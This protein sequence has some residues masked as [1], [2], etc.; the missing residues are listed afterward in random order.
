MTEKE[1]ISKREWEK[2]GVR[3]TE[4]L[5]PQNG[6]DESIWNNNVGSNYKR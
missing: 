1:K 5:D 3:G 4:G 6:L 2:Y